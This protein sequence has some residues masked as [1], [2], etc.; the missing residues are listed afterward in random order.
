MAFVRRRTTK[1]GTVSTTLV[2]SYRNEQGEPRQRV[3]A[4]L[5]GADTPLEALAKLAAQREQL[6][7]ERAALEPD[8]E[9]AAGF[10]E[11]ITA[12]SLGGHKFATHER[13]EIDRLMT[14]RGRLLRRVEKLD[15][16]LVRIQRDGAAIK[17]HVAASDD[18]IQAAIRDPRGV[19][20]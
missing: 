3:V 16:T 20:S 5:H 15:S 17:Q 13:Q 19:G 9:G 12:A 7:E 2:E 11:S 8:L 14:A 1:A 4:N 6:R 18:Q 10:Y